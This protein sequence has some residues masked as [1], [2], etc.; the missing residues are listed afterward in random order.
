MANSVRVVLPQGAGC[1]A[2]RAA[3]LLTQE[4]ERRSGAKA[5]LDGGADGA[6]YGRTDRH[7]LRQPRPTPGRAALT[8]GTLPHH[9]AGR[10]TGTK[11]TRTDSR[12]HT[13]EESQCPS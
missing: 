1:L 7:P 10:G 9:Q 6:A 13:P 2:D 12:T 11:L 8:E 3:A 4:I 5:V